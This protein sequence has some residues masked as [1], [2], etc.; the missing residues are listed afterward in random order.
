MLPITFLMLLIFFP[1]FLRLFHFPFHDIP[2]GQYCSKGRHMK[3]ICLP[4]TAPNTAQG[5]IYVCVCVKGNKMNLKCIMVKGSVSLQ[6]CL[7]GRLWRDT[8]LKGSNVL[9]CF[10]T[11]KSIPS[12]L[13]IKKNQ[14]WNDP[15]IKKIRKQGHSTLYIPAGEGKLTSCHSLFIAQL[16]LFSI[17]LH[18]NFK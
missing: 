3:I 11:V 9:G 15:C 6:M 12:F 7:E 10:S 5:R 2:C 16:L 4:H 1:S 13:I 14:A 8:P 17:D 18:I